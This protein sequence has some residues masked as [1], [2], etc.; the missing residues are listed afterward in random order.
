M[1]EKKSELSQMP[2]K[3]PF[4][5]GVYMKDLHRLRDISINQGIYFKNAH[6]INKCMRKWHVATT[7]TITSYLQEVFKTLVMANVF[8]NLL[9]ELLFFINFPKLKEKLFFYLQEF[10][11]GP[12]C[13]EV[14]L[15]LRRLSQKLVFLRIFLLTTFSHCCFKRWC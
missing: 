7:P 6:H 8:I 13:V 1:T 11:F 14:T 3:R 15:L 12:A 5:F 4:N 2:F 10:Y 9:G